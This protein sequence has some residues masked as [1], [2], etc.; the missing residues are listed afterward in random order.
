[1]ISTD[2]DNTRQAD[3]ALQ[4]VESLT[5]NGSDSMP[6]P[7]S[8]GTCSGPGSAEWERCKEGYKFVFCVSTMCSHTCQGF[9]LGDGQDQ[10]KMSPADALRLLSTHPVSASSVQQ[11]AR[12]RKAW[13]YVRDLEVWKERIEC[14]SSATMLSW[15]ACYSGYDR[16]SG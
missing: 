14:K 1:M 13:A 2:W 16:Y 7:L 10:Q 15:L 6:S 5:N 3:E 12:K 9:H 8:R 11:T 4:M